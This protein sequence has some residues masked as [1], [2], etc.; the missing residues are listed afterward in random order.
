MIFNYR[1]MIDKR[2]GEKSVRIGEAGKRRIGEEKTTNRPS[3]ISDHP[4]TEDNPS[5]KRLSKEI[6]EFRSR[7]QEDEEIL[8]AIRSGEVDALVISGPQGKRSL[9]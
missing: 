2:S 9:P 8:R 7:P 1:L 3:A 6:R 5:L 4:V